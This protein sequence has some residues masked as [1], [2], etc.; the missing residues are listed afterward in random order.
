MTDRSVVARNPIIAKYIC[1]LSRCRV[2]DG[3]ACTIDRHAVAAIKSN[4]EWVHQDLDFSSAH[5]Y[6]A[7][8]IVNFY[9]DAIPWI[10]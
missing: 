7:R 4:T 6:T 9:I 2:Y 8:E 5:G 1:G 3:N 10:D